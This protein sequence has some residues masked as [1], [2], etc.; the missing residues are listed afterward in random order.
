MTRTQRIMLL[1]S[2][3]PATVLAGNAPAVP[4]PE[5]GVLSLLGLG[6]AVA[7]AVAI[8]KRR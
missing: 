4:V 1:V 3:S 2:L 5:P 6:V 8:K 7:V